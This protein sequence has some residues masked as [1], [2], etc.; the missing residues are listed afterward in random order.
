MKSGGLRKS[1]L[2]LTVGFVAAV[3]AVP[4]GQIAVDLHGGRHVQ[5][6]DVFRRPP[7]EAN[8][9]RYEDALESRS[10]FQQ[11]LRGPTQRV[12]LLTLRQTGPKAV[13]GRGRWL[14]YR[15]GVRYLIEPDEPR[16]PHRDWAWARPTRG[17]TA[18]E[19]AVAAIVR[20]RDQLRGRGIDLLV[21]PTP[22]KASVYPDRLTARCAGRWRRFRSPTEDLLAELAHRG[23]RAVDLFSLFRELRAEDG[24]RL[25]YL[26]QDTH[27]TPAGAERAAEAVARRLR[28]LG[29]PTGSADAASLPAGR[30]FG[31]RTIRVRRYGDIVEMMQVGGAREH[32]GYTDVTCRQVVDAAAGMLVP[33]RTWHEGAYR[34]PGG[35]ARVLVLGDSFSRIY[36]TREPRRLG[37]VLGAADIPRAPGPRRYLPG[38]A[39]FASHLARALGAPVDYIVSDGGAATDVRRKLSINPEILEHKRVVV[40]QFAERDVALGAGGWQDVPLPP[41]LLP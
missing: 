31:V 7:T 33:G 29:W 27:W 4:V 11:T 5:F 32:F 35:K 8:L 21:V 23:V 9:R 24:D 16:P 17:P 36:Q 39:G 25:W 41:E 6:T 1:E 18:R 12:L 19:A 40:W 15:P 38:S 37:E 34:H 20:F 13:L 30:A 10:W 22:G 26:P 2:A 3:F 14:F 28:A